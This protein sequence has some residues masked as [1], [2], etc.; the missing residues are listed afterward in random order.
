MWTSIL[1]I[2]AVAFIVGVS[3]L[4]GSSLNKRGSGSKDGKRH[5][6]SRQEA[7][8]AAKISGAFPFRKENQ[9]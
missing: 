9:P 6:I 3:W 7:V 2:V 1:F 4:V 8:T 5:G